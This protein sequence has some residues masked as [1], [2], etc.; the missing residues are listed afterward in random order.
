[1]ERQPLAPTGFSDAE[2]RRPRRETGLRVDELA[3][4]RWEHVSLR[5]RSGW[6]DVVGKRR[7]HRRVPLNVK[8]RSAR[9]AIRPTNET[10]DGHAFYGKRGPYTARGTRYLVAEV[11]RPLPTLPG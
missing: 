1:V 11:R 2:R 9:G 10:L 6:V 5:E 8:A 7:K 3:R 4:L